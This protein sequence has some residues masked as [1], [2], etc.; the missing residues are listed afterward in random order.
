MR[1]LSGFLALVSLS[2]RCVLRWV[3]WSWGVPCEALVWDEEA[4]ASV[5]WRGRLHREGTGSNPGGDGD[6]A[7][8][9]GD[10]GDVGR[11]N[12]LTEALA[13]AGASSVPHLNSQS[14]LEHC[15]RVRDILREM[16][17]PEHVC[18]AGL[19]HSAYGSELFPEAVFPVARRETLA[20]LI[21]DAAEHLVYLYGTASQVHL[22]RTVLATPVDM[23][24][25]GD[26]RHEDGDG[27]DAAATSRRTTRGDGGDGGGGDGDAAASPGLRP[28]GM[29][30]QNFYTRE[31]ALLP[32]E[33]AAALVVMHV[34]DLLAVA[35][36][37][38]WCR[39]FARHA[40]E[41]ARPHLRRTG[42]RG[43]GGGSAGASGG[44][45]NRDIAGRAPPWEWATAPGE[46]RDEAR[47]HEALRRRLRSSSNSLLVHRCCS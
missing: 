3:C 42:E 41:A 12:R 14:L 2:V 23:N 22:Y 17:A 45:P 8:Q 5:R 7:G 16:G 21:G 33:T 40:F 27:L 6:G 30:V 32:P 24:R 19:F 11:G 31:A 20:A 44:R 26:D 34:A 25:R 28:W 35:R 13:S 47:R 39:T 29:P 9:G 38:E 10:A 4:R 43:K 1:S 37:S 36:P 46:G 15:A 18:D